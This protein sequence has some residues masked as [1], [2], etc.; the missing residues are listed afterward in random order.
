M[1][2]G[3][4]HDVQ[5]CKESNWRKDCV[6][7]VEQ[8]HLTLVVGRL[9]VGEHHVQP[10]L[11]GREFTGKLLQRQVRCGLYDPQMESFGLHHHLIGIAHFLL[12]GFNVLAG[13][14]RHDAVHKRC[15]YVA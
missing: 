6:R 12:N 7:T 10:G 4:T 9:V 14:T 3:I 2:T 11:V 5:T 13:E 1:L 8:C 15:A